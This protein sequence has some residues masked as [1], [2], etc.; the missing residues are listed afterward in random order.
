MQMLAWST[1]DF[2]NSNKEFKL[3]YQKYTNVHIANAS[4]KKRTEIKNGNWNGINILYKGKNSN[5]NQKH[6]H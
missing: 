5:I 2:L 6:K 3:I 1:F 4:S